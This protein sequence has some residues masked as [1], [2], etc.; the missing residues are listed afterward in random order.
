MAVVGLAEL[1]VPVALIARG[2]PGLPLFIDRVSFNLFGEVGNGWREQEPANLTAL[3]DFGGEAAL[4]LG[5]GAGLTMR[6]R[7]GGAIALSDGLGSRKGDVRY[8]VAFGR[9]F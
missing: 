3:R 9:A 1:R 6:L 4:D 5:V 7:L 2:V 8:Y